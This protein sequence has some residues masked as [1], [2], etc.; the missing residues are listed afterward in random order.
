LI[1]SHPHRQQP[2]V[3]AG[4]P[5][6]P[7]TNPPAEALRGAYPSCVLVLRHFDPLYLLSARL[8]ARRTSVR[9]TGRQGA[10]DQPYACQSFPDDEPRLSRPRD[11]RLHIRMRRFL[12]DISTGHLGSS[13]GILEC[14]TRRDAGA[15]DRSGLEN[16]L[17]EPTSGFN[18]RA[19]Y[20]VPL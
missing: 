7:S 11:R 16:C 20:A 5:L 3:R 15:V 6:I 4:E 17:G 1:P 18:A 19:W 14:P 12:G 9:H 13:A 2:R 10:R 8:I